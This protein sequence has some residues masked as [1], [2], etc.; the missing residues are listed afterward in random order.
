MQSSRGFWVWRWGL[1]SW[2]A[3]AGCQNLPVAD[4]LP[5]S[6]SSGDQPSAARRADLP[7][8]K[9]AEVCLSVAETLEKNGLYAD[10][11]L[12]VEKAHQYNP[13]LQCARRLALL[14]DRSGDIDRALAQY[15]EALKTNSQDANLLNDTGYCCY[16]AGHFTDAEHYL[17]QAVVINDR[18][19]RA[20]IN[21]GMTLGQ[22]Q[23]YQESLD[24]FTRGSSRPE[25]LCDLGYVY[26]TQGKTEEAKKLYTQALGLRP[27]LAVART[28]LAKLDQVKTPAA[29][30]KAPTSAGASAAASAL[31]PTAAPPTSASAATITPASGSAV[32]PG[33]SYT[34]AM[35][36]ANLPSLTSALPTPIMANPPATA[37]SVPVS[38]PAAATAG[39][40]SAAV[41]NSIGSGISPV[42]ASPSA[43]PSPDPAA[44]VSTAVLASPSTAPA[45]PIWVPAA[46]R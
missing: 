18:H 16:R 2:I 29:V 25:A 36:M 14:Y 17:R 31:V 45:Q 44:A 9:A 3:A 40:P 23:R 12:Q 13:R 11:A 6:S 39:A 41:A 32:A 20:W 24:A 7:P 5:T 15:R 35:P 37:P 46:K 10:A 34:D 33:V 26:A 8:D 42:A 1:V 22:E 28:A 30:A 21:L 43:T 19:Q 4:S 27:D 38:A